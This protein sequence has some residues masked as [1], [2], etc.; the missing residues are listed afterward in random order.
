MLAY[1]LDGEE[2]RKM[3]P[4]H[5]KHDLRLAY[6]LL[7][8]LTGQ[9]GF[10][11]RYLKTEIRAYL[12]S[13]GVLPNFGRERRIIRDDGI[14]GYLELVELPESVTTEPDARDY[15]EACIEIRPMPAIYDCTGRAF[16]SWY[17]LFKRRGHYF[18]YHDVS[19]DV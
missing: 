3:F 15:F 19:F 17:K 12:K 11:P 16:T 8:L 13:D 10:D 6:E 18:A 14:D 2:G 7:N 5:S 9:P 1:R 4:I